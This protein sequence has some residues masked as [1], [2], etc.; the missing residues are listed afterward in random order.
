MTDPRE[1][2]TVDIG[3]GHRVRFYRDENGAPRLWVFHD[4]PGFPQHG[5]RC[6]SYIPLTG[7]KPWRLVSE[8]PLTIEPSIHF[9]DCGDHGFIRNG[10]WVPA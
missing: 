3:H 10:K 8:D 4:C 2:P 5:E 1:T 9:T 7:P 6:G